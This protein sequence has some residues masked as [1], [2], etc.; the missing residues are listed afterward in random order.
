MIM[1]LIDRALLLCEEIE[2]R[3]AELRKLLDVIAGLK[4]EVKRPDCDADE[5]YSRAGDECAVGAE[6]DEDVHVMEKPEE[7]E[8]EKESVLPPCH[9]PVPE[10]EKPAVGGDLRKAF[11]INDRFRFRRE[12][13]GG[14]DKAFV[15][16]VDRLSALGSF[17]DAERC[18]DDLG[19]NRDDEAVVEFKEIVSK[20]FN[21]YHL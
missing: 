16:L 3:Q 1:E 5:D 6:A 15:A 9:A 10:K 21:G 20:F 17:E 4:D 19:W 2:K 8:E 12:L 13:F 18:V 7:R 14:D 11:T